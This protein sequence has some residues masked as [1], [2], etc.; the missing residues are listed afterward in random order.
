MTLNSAPNY[1]NCGIVVDGTKLKMYVNDFKFE[2]EESEFNALIN[3]YYNMV[4]SVMKPIAGYIQDEE[5]HFI[6][7]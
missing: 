5:M 2:L 6:S 3:L 1:P 4:Q 7:R